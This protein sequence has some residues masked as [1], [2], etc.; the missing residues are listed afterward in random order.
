[1]P[2]S[3]SSSNNGGSTNTPSVAD[4][5]Q[6]LSEAQLRHLYDEEEVE[7]FMHFFSAYVTEVRLPGIPAST[8]NTHPEVPA[9]AESAGAMTPP[10]LPRRPTDRSLSEYIA[11]EYVLPYLPPGANPSPQFTLKR[12]RLTSQRFYLATVPPYQTFLLDLAHLALWNDYQ[13]STRYCICF[14]FL[15]FHDLLLPA[16]MFRI[17]WSLLR[18]RLLPYHTLQE[19]QERREAT[20]RARLFGEEVQERLSV[21]TLG[22]IDMWRLFKLYKA[23]TKEK[24]SMKENKFPEQESA[25]LAVPSITNK[26][27]ETNNEPTLLDHGDSQEEECL[28]R[29]LLHLLN[30][31]ADLH[32]RIKNIFTWRRPAVSRRYAL[33]LAIASFGVL[34]LP[35]QYVAKLAY[36]FGGIAFWHVVPV[37]AALPR[38]DI[39]RQVNLVP[40]AFGD[41]PTD[42]DYAMELIARRIAAGQDVGISVQRNNH[43]HRASNAS[44][45]SLTV[46]SFDISHEAQSSDNDGINWKKWGGRVAH[47]KSLMEEGKQ[48]MSSRV[49]SLHPSRQTPSMEETATRAFPAQYASTPGLITLTPTTLYFTSLT[50]TRAKLVIPCDRL[51]GVKKSGLV[52]GISMVWVPTDS[53][54]GREREERF[55]WVGNRDELFA[56]LLGPDGGRWMR[57]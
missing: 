9:E 3:S 41:A 47:G 6:G 28:K 12:L 46:T 33:L 4:D 18:H 39:A 54:D 1:M 37:V 20:A 31:L 30:E 34:A 26:A 11:Y 44:T 57:I 14:W 16:L 32:E 23:G 45:V 25:N 8:D 56:R 27:A 13:R 48:L 22:P 29:D 49:R 36:L 15:W 43:R 52:K 51:R 5:S 17:L 2:E 53:V 24:I 40:P 21:T 55:H 10:L 42:A 50:S 7:R 35:A 38:A 19:L